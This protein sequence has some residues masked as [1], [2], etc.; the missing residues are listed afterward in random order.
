MIAYYGQFEDPAAAPETAVAAEEAAEAEENMTAGG[1]E[2]H[3]EPEELGEDPI[4][5]ALDL[6][7]E[8]A[9][10]ETPDPDE[11]APGELTPE[12]EGNAERFAT[13]D[14]AGS[15]TDNSPEGAGPSSAEEK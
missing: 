9:V 15:P 2:P 14:D 1:S 6:G 3:P 12:A 10:E 5:N 11:D 8:H 7:V 13:I 4:E